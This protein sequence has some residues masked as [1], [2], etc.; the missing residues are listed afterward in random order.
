MTTPHTIERIWPGYTVAVLASGPSLTPAIAGR[1][2]K[3]ADR[4]IAVNAAHRLAPWAD[5][6][7]AL[8]GNWPAEYRTFEGMRITGVADDDLNALYIGP[9]FETIRLA[10]G[11]TIE[12]ANSGLTAVRLA[13]QMGAAT[14]ILAGFDWPAREGHFYDD[15]P[16]EYPGN[17]EGLAAIVAELTAAGIT[18]RAATPTVAVP[19]VPAVPAGKAPRAKAPAPTPAPTPMPAP[20]D[21]VPEPA[22]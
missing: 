17:V 21:A 18:V 11:H 15:S 8:D 3:E 13:A 20:A 1:L 5:A 9:R 10:E 12:V 7:V 6:L 2:R 16:E 14:I 4:V 19:T 22:P